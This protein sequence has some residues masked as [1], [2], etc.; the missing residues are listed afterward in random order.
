[1][2]IRTAAWYSKQSNTFSD[3]LVEVRRVLWRERYFA[4]V[5]ENKDL[6]EIFTKEG[7]VAEI[8][9]HLAEAI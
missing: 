6:I 1:V 7:L 5:A 2:P 4:Q 3:I 9:E 8:L